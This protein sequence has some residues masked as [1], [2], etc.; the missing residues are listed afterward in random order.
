MGYNLT[1]D[2]GNSA[3]KVV[4]WHN[5]EFVADSYHESLTAEAVKLIVERH[6]I[7]SAIY[8]SVA[9]RGDDIV[10]AL[11]VLCDKVIELSHKTPMPLVIDYNSPATLGRDRIAAAA[12]AYSRF[13][14]KTVLV[15]DLGTAITYDIVSADAHFR[16]GNIAPGLT[17]R[18][19]AL[20]NCTA[21]LPQVTPKG[22]CPAWGCDTETAIRAGAIMGIVG[23]ISHYKSI[24][25]TDTEVILTGG[26]APMIK[27]LLGFQTEIDE[28]LVNYGLNCILQ[29]NENK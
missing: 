12:G 13:P 22:E 15:V 4:I 27:P 8:S 7:T 18:L 26:S 6:S 9:E 17:M 20:H 28:H 10:K 5:D 21:R 16:G 25:P 11:N 19:Q 29:Y 23:E 24:L 1:I 14:G 3:A 2:Q